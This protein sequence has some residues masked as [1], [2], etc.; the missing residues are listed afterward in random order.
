VSVARGSRDSKDSKWLSAIDQ[1][2]IAGIRQGRAKKRE[3]I[4]RILELVPEWNRGDCW[5]R[6]RY[7]RKTLQVTA[8]EERRR[9][10]NPNSFGEGAVLKR[11]ASRPWTPADDD[12]LLQLAGYE[13]VKR[14]AQRLDRSIRAVRFR[15]GALGMSAKVTDGWSLRALR[16]MLRVSP[17][18]LRYLMAYG[19]L[20]VRDPR[21]LLSSL[22]TF[23]E[24]NHASLTGENLERVATALSNGDEA[25]SWERT[26]ELLGVESGQLQS[27]ISAGQLKLF[28]TFVTDRA[29]EE[30]CKKHG[31]EINT[32][33]MDP[34]TAKWLVSEYGVT[35]A[36]D[37]SRSVS[38]A[39]KH[40]LVVRTCACGR[41]IAGNVYFRHVKICPSAVAAAHRS[42]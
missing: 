37:R 13:P 3:A 11:S 15:L 4:N 12:R 5:Q 10:G 14:I 40:A 23:C 36:A 42:I 19:L 38:R 21:I 16:Q 34:A 2:L 25:F 27:L 7:L 29:F 33:L 18:R 22:A 24:T 6:I 26:A 8:P 39:Q 17:A 31:G 20:R 1:L 32:V 28:D 35:N 30:F 41:K 9:P